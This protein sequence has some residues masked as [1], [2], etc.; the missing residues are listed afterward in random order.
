MYE[1]RQQKFARRA[2]KWSFLDS[3]VIFMII[4]TIVNQIQILAL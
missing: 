1:V 3:Y 4:V 2:Y